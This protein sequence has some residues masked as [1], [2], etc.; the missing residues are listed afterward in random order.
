MEHVYNHKPEFYDNSFEIYYST[1]PYKSEVNDTK[2]KGEAL[3]E[4]NSADKT[5][6]LPKE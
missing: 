6:I 2:R 3:K 4:K 1:Q 5:K